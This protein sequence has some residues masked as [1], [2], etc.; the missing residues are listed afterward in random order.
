MY[1]G[2]VVCPA[3][4]YSEQAV[5]IGTVP[6]TC[7]HEFVAFGV[8]PPVYLYK[9]VL[10]LVVHHN[11]FIVISVSARHTFLHGLDGCIEHPCGPFLVEAVKHSNK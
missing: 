7:P 2:V 5:A 3:K 4:V 11:L 9:T 1:V 8:T 10:R 6:V